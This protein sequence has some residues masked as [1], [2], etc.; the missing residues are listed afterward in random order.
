MV[1][2]AITGASAVVFRT[3]ES[4]QMARLAP[5]DSVWKISH[6]ETPNT[7][8]VLKGTVLPS[9]RGKTRRSQPM[10][11]SSGPWVTTT[12][13][14][15]PVLPEV[16]IT[17]ADGVTT[18][19][20]GLRSI[21]S[22]VCDAT[23]WFEITHSVCERHQWCRGREQAGGKLCIA[24]EHGSWLRFGQHLNNAHLRVRRL[25][26]QVAATRLEHSEYGHDHGTGSLEDEADQLAFG[27]Q[28]GRVR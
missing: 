6:S 10:R 11:L 20:C 3:S 19:V 23:Q 17:L 15:R 25:D 8:W 27:L 2:R 1:Q 22:V 12:P 9:W 26:W 7:Y 21:Q 4:G 14:G 24:N 5:A 13:L 18:Q 28:V 16:Y